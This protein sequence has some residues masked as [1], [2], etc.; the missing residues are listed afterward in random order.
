M[1]RNLYHE[2][3]ERI[4]A[5]LEAGAPPWI[6]PWR[7]IG[8]GN[9]IPMNAVSHRPYSG[10]NV[11]M[12]WMS[13]HA[14]NRWITFHQ[15]LE[16]GGN[17][18]KGSHGTRIYYVSSYTRKDKD[19]NETT[20]RFLKEYTVFNVLQ[21]EN[22]P[23]RCFA[24]E[25]APINTD[26]RDDEAED[27]IKLTGAD[28]REGSGEAY[29]SP[30]GDFI[31]MPSFKNFKNS[32]TYYATCWHEFGH[33]SGHKSRLDRDLSGRFGDRSYAGEEL[34]AE[35]CS[36][37]LCAEWGF[38]AEVRHASYIQNWISLLKADD[39]AFFTAASKAQQSANYL[40]SLALEEPVQL[41]AE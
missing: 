25:P 21:C 36:A 9:K 24:G 12:L 1:A 22:L 16:A 15:A 17:V 3:S 6:K 10:A 33:W 20:A 30:G 40:R 13:G 32:D 38:D 35:L 11:I 7:S 31:S 27:F 2:V 41:A 34:V 37:F 14:S 29:F 28:F 8:R 19:D 23:E 18:R 4:L 39:R 5:E 26:E